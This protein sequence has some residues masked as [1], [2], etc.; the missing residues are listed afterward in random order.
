MTGLTAWTTIT[1]CP[2]TRGRETR[3][4]DVSDLVRTL[5]RHEDVLPCL[6]VLGTAP[7]ERRSADVQ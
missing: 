2:V 5:I 3:A 1:T 7:Y 4:D 6:P